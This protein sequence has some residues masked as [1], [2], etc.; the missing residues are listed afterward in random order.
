MKIPRILFGTSP[1]IGA[2]QFGERTFEYRRRFYGNPENMTTL[3]VKSAQF[4][5]SAVQLI[6]Y[7]PLVKALEKAEKE[8]GNF[9]VLAAIIENFEESMEL[10]SSLSPEA[11]SIHARFCDCSDPRLDGWIEKIRNAGAIPV[12]S[13]HDPARSIPVLEEIDFDGYLTP[14]NPV[15]YGMGDFDGTLKAIK[16][17]SRT[18]IAMKT[19]AA[20]EL[21]PDKDLF[22]FVYS[23]AD[24]A[25]VGIT[26]VEE[27]E[28]TYSK[29]REALK[30]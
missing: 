10:L 29:M 22:E 26:S 13:T 9:F 11:I 18:I 4:G 12:A 1:F 7:E 14:L 25:A 5:V 16:N 21:K 27:M 17:T 19:L 15:G 20:G 3:F 23:Y 6:A 8:A 2:G 24:A 28:E 30:P